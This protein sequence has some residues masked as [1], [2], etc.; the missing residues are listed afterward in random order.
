LL[1]PGSQRRID[2][3]RRRTHGINGE[4]PQ[5][6]GGEQRA[7]GGYVCALVVLVAYRVALREWFSNEGFIAEDDELAADVF[8][9]WL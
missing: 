2:G 4:Q 8:A 1:W 7:H 6:D 3:G 9:P 5:I